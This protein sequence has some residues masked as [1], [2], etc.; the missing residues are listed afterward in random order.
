MGEAPWNLI[1]P[2][3]SLRRGYRSCEGQVSMQL[4]AWMAI[5]GWTSQRTMRGATEGKKVPGAGVVHLARSRTSLDSN[6][7]D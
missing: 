3:H 6:D 2:G 1:R 5:W 4:F 7:C